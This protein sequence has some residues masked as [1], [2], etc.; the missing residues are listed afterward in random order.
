MSSHISTRQ[1]AMRIKSICRDCLHSWIMCNNCNYNIHATIRRTKAA[2]LHTNTHTSALRMLSASAEGSILNALSIRV[3][4]ERTS[5]SVQFNCYGINKLTAVSK[6]IVR[7]IYATPSITTTRFGMEWVQTPKRT[8]RHANSHLY[9]YAFSCCS[10]L[11]RSF[12]R[13]SVS[14]KYY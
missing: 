7:Y 11:A 13:V 2:A 3:R 5:Q 14:I 1:S 10:R 9:S 6:S 12:V 8:G 4:S